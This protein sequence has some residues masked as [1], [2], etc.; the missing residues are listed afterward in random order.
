MKT[1]GA[2]MAILAL[3]LLTG[4]RLYQNKV[5][6]DAKTALASV[7]AESIPVH[8][9]KTAYMEIPH[10][11]SFNGTLKS[12]QEVTLNSKSMGFVEKKYKS[13]GDCVQRGEIIAQLESA[14]EA[15]LLRLA[16]L[17]FE[18]AAKDLARSS[19][20]LK[21]NATHLK[22]HE[23]VDATYRQALKTLADCKEALKDKTLRA[24]LSGII[25]KDYFEEGSL[26]GEG[27]AVAEIVAPGLK[28]IINVTERDVAKIKKGDQAVIIAS[29]RPNTSVQGTVRL[30]TLRG[31]ASYTYTVEILLDEDAPDLKPGMYAGVSFAYDTEEKMLTAPRTALIEGVQN[32]GVYVV[33]GGMVYKKAV[34]IGKYND[35]RVEI[36]A[37]LQEGIQ[38]V[39]S[40]QITLR[41]GLSV[42]IVN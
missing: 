6:I 14:Y 28:L 8:A 19:A 16:T 10:I 31:S 30:V 20:L 41:D 22:A 4:V 9:E 33:D 24:P 15:E 42:R 36:T 39:T 34:T 38:V 21:L 17:D 25:D 3:L 13:A 18:T 5:V 27:D 7:A 23:L 12:V 35:E 1:F 40:G 26:L 32:P 37:G 29:S 11:L 2:T